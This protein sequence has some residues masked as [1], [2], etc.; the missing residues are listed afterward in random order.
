MDHIEQ[1]GP[2]MN[3]PTE[4]AIGVT[5]FKAHC[6]T[7]I[8]EVARGKRRRVLL[9][10][11]NH[12]IAAIVPVDQPKVKLW[13]ALRGSIKIAKGADITKSTGQKW[14]AEG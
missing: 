6:L 11:H 9:K 5:D 8:N 12:P 14:K 1:R 2:T 4:H 10:R 7:L 3:K 13:G